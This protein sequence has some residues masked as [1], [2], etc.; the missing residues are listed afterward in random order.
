MRL[1]E[2]PKPP[3]DAEKFYGSPP[4]AN[5]GYV[6]QDGER[7]WRF[8]AE[9]LKAYMIYMEGRMLLIWSRPGG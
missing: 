2:I 4:Y 7:R 3:A 9:G 5:E 1:E 8:D 6:I